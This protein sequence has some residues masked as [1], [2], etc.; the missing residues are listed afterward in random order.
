MSKLFLFILVFF[1]LF[2]SA[3]TST[4]VS[5]CLENGAYLFRVKVKRE[6]TIPTLS[7]NDG[8]QTCEW[9]TSII[10]SDNLSE[11]SWSQQAVPGRLLSMIGSN[12]DSHYSLDGFFYNEA[13][14]YEAS[15]MICEGMETPFLFVKTF[16]KIPSLRGRHRN[17][18]LERC[19]KGASFFFRSTEVI[20]GIYSLDRIGAGKDYIQDLGLL[21]LQFVTFSQLWDEK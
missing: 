14:D 19:T 1:P 6:A 9:L 5:L 17:L 15:E 4:S 8:V 11:T 20:Q 7:R 10:L 21:D 13:K 3:S 12:V 2:S 16:S 18:I